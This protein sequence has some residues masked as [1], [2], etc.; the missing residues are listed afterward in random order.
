MAGGALADARAAAA[1]VH[2]GPPGGVNPAELSRV[3]EAR[4]MA[5][6]H[7]LRARPARTREQ[8]PA[9]LQPGRARTRPPWPPPFRSL[10][11]AP[12]A[13]PRR[14]LA[15]SRPGR[16]ARRHR[17]RRPRHTGAPASWSNR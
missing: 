1:G 8:A 13:M 11:R 5:A 4:T 17:P 3:A 10:A 15:R 14:P 12:T 16:R 2:D 7:E 6:V 9:R